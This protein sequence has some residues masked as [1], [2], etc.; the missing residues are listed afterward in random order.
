MTER[1]VP[2]LPPKPPLPPMPGA[3]SSTAVPR[4][5]LHPKIKAGAKTY[6]GIML[7][8]II[9]AVGAAQQ[10]L[11]LSPAAALGLT[12]LGGF[13]PLLAGFLKMGDGR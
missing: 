10:G 13:L 1:P 8:G 6:G 2:P 4:E 7:A 5:D 11:T 9:A 12:A 3:S